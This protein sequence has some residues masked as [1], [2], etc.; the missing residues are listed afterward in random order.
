M[1]E[2]ERR[3]R[4]VFLHQFNVHQQ[5]S[6]ETMECNVCGRLRHADIEAEAS[7]VEDMDE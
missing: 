7:E 1:A 5:N 4:C 3:L 6:G 2:R